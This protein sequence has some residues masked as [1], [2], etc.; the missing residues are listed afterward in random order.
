MLWLRLRP[1]RL[2][3]GFSCIIAAVIYHPP[4]AE[5]RSIREH[6]FQSLTLAESRYPKCGLLITGDFNRLNINRLLNH[7]RLKQIVKASTRENAILD[8][9][10]TNMHENY[11]APKVY[12]PFGLSD[13]NTVV[14]FPKA[15]DLNKINKKKLITS[16]DRRTSRKN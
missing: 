7:F 10:L 15:E 8:L 2:A 13:H 6:L 12:P 4:G 5:E 11:S 16:R 14:A 9:I 1:R 3:R